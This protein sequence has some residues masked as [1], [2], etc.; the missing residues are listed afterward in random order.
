MSLDSFKNY[1]RENT[2]SRVYTSG[3]ASYIIHKTVNFI[4][5]LA[6]ENKVGRKIRDYKRSIYLFT[7]DEIHKLKELKRKFNHNNH[8]RNGKH[9]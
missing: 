1:L 8:N 3:E 2:K 4:D 5:K 7:L 6:L 9:I